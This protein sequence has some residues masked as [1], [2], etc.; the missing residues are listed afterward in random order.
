MKNAQAGGTYLYAV[1]SGTQESGEVGPIGIGGGEVYYVTAGD[2]R[3]AVSRVSRARLRP[4]RKH[5]LAH[6]QSIT[7]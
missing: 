6:H 1:L 3:A 2:L 7:I 5:L 4:E